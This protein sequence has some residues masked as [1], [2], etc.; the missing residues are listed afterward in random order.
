MAISTTCLCENVEMF[1]V[2]II[3]KVSEKP[4]NPQR[5]FEL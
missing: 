5:C 4:N 3:E 2:K 1:P